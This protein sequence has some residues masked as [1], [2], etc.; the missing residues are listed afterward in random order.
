[1]IMLDNFKHNI[2]TMIFVD[3]ATISIQLDEEKAEDLVK[4]EPGFFGALFSSITNIFSTSEESVGDLIADLSKEGVLVEIDIKN[5]SLTKVLDMY[6]IQ[7][8]PFVIILKGN[9]VLYR[10]VAT[11][12][13]AEKVQAIRKV[14]N[15]ERSRD[16]EEIV[17]QKSDHNQV[18]TIAPGKAEL[19][20]DKNDQFLLG[21]D[22]AIE[23]SPSDQGTTI[24]PLKRTTTV[25]S[26][27]G[28][29][30]ASEISTAV[31]PV[32][33]NVE[34]VKPELA[35]PEP[36]KPEL[37]R[38]VKASSETSKT[39]TVVVTPQRRPLKDE[40]KMNMTAFTQSSEISVAPAADSV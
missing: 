23:S 4:S 6:N 5:P 33:S 14:V 15:E 9:K 39:E 30:S 24:I 18:V 40:L 2:T 7:T 25:E 35:R 20:A 36:A 11:K 1:M 17:E 19:K 16:S 38:T 13:A 8:T 32:K 28:N 3:P 22:Q 10:D 21:K 31:Q 12:K 27:S 34:F 37:R 29:K 26:Q